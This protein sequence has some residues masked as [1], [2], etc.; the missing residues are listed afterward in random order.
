MTR[1]AWTANERTVNEKN[2]EIERRREWRR[3]G[4]IEELEDEVWCAARVTYLQ[5]IAEE[6]AKGEEKKTLEEMIPEAYREFHKVFSEE[7]SELRGRIYED[8]FLLT[9]FR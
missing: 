7:E 9:S 4:V 3:E 1:E 2:E 8:S 6:A 5:Q